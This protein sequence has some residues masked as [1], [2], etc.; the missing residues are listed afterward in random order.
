MELK[1]NGVVVSLA[2]RDKGKLLVITGV[3]GGHVYVCDGKERPLLK[4]KRKNV[5]HV[6]ALK[7]VL[8]SEKTVSDPALRKALLEIRGHMPNESEV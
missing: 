6:R 1:T 5:K 2:G 4:P 7:Y 8:S 3:D